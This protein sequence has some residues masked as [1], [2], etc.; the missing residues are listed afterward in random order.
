MAVSQKSFAP[1]RH[2]LERPAFSLGQG[3]HGGK[4]RIKRQDVRLE[5]GQSLRREFCGDVLNRHGVV[6]IWVFHHRRPRTLVPKGLRPDHGR[7]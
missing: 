2:A 4:L 3:D 1:G 5:V 7:R 6:L